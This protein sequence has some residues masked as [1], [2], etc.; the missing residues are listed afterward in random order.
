MITTA[1]IIPWSLYLLLKDGAFAA[2]GGAVCE[3]VLF[4]AGVSYSMPG[5]IT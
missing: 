1:A 4:I 2:R 5:A 3:P